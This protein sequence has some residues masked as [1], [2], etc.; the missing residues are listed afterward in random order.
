M[1]FLQTLLHAAVFALGMAWKT[2]WTLVLGFTISS[3]IQS[4][5]S[6]E[7]MRDALGR[8]GIRQISL[9]TAMGAASSSCSYASAAIM[10]TLFK[11][12]AALV[13]AL[14]FMFASTNLVIELGIIL[15]ILMGWQFMVGEWVGGLVLIAIMA[16]IVRFTL[17]DKLVEAARNHEEAG[18]GHEHS[19]ML[20]EGETWW[21]RLT[22][23]QARIRV[24]QNFTMEF[25][26]LWKDLAIGFVVGGI[27]TAF[28]PDRF[29]QAL[30]LTDA[31]PWLQAPANAV[32]G[33]VVAV[34]TFVCSIGN[35]PLAAVLFAGGASFGGVLAFLY[36]DL[37]VL[38]LLDAYRRYLGWKMAAYMGIVF[39]VTMVIAGLIME[40][41]FAA[42]GIVPGHDTDIRQQ[43]TT[44]AFDY[45][46][47]LNLVFGALGI[48]WWWTARRNPMHHHH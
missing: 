40:L 29:W 25:S 42:L 38:P 48:Y 14:A 6:T 4:V 2:L 30:F 21:R 35:V 31:S 45:T 11:K 18:G 10:R 27:L 33:P 24:A 46:F 41:A 43:L 44:F 8:G 34:F 17:S 19:A 15:L 23:P 1:D 26:M 22:N 28:V 5:V 37:I 13:N 32:I 20:V 47:W 39:F 36:A 9:A 3:V 16:M 12:G 7:A